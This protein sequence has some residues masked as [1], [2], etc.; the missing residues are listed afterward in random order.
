MAKWKVTP[1]FKKSV[2]ERQSWNKDGNTFVYEIGWRWGEFVIHTDDDN[3]PVL[4]E[5]I[6]IYNC[7]YES[8]VVGCDDGCWDDYDYSE[9]DAEACEWLDQFFDDGNSVFELEDRGWT[10]DETELSINCEMEI[11]M[12]EPT[13]A[14][15]PTQKGTWPY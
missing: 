14:V 3:P 7:G 2:V 1:K 6:D 10:N 8:E 5:G 9:C 4:E 11:E 15:T 13:G 12:I